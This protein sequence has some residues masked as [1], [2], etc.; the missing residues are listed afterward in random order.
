MLGNATLSFATP[1]GSAETKDRVDNALILSFKRLF[2]RDKIKRET[3][4]MRMFYSASSG[5]TGKNLNNTSEVDER[6]FT[7]FG[8]ATS[9]RRTFGGEVGD[10]VN[11]ND[12]SDK[13]GLVFYD[14]GTVILN[15]DRVISA[16]Q[17]V[18]GVIA[19]MHAGVVNDVTN[20][21]V[22][23]GRHSCRVGWFS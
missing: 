11:A 1:F 5:Q 20:G 3:F 4:A 18:S 19:G 10:L 21:S 14:A 22:V 2:T 23:I 7:D 6:I 16:S 15:V 8:A 9:R 17:P 13:V 12:T